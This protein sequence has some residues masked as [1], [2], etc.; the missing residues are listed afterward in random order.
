MNSIFRI[1]VML[2]FTVF[3]CSIASA[4]NLPDSLKTGNT[5]QNVENGNSLEKIQTKQNPE[6]LPI[7]NKSILSSKDSPTK[8]LKLYGSFTT[9]KYIIGPNDIINVSLLGVPDLSQNSIKVK[10]DGKIDLSGLGDIKVAGLTVNEVRNKLNE[11]Y[12]YYVKNPAVSVKLERSRP[13]IVQVT[14]AVSIPG[15]Y[16]INTDTETGNAIYN[17]DK[18]FVER[19][20]PILSNVLIAAGGVN[21]DA[22]LKHI[23][24]SNNIEG[25]D[26]EVNALDMLKKSKSSGDIYLMAGDSVYV[27]KLPSPLAVKEANYKKFAHAAFANRIVPVRVLGYVNR[28]GL[29]NLDT[30]LSSTLNTAISQAG[31]YQSNAA[32]PPKRVFVSR[33]DNNGK[34]VTTIVNPMENDITLMPNDVVYVPEKT[35]PLI[36]KA[37]DFMT[38]VVAPFS[39]IAGGYNNWALIF[40]PTRLY[41]GN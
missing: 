32:Y 9:R 40:D 26:Y 13:F 7:R 8:T 11:K 22:D 31:G 33:V 29:I 15:S 28:P 4:E 1:A 10:P 21:Y 37:F 16:E 19:K 6:E 14:G 20:T 35:R 3:A 41:G 27:P 2:I 34:M 38:R 17:N 5:P 39:S 18:T 25:I 12:A 30:S 23:V 24:I 36:G